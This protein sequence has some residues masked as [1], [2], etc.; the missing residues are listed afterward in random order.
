M[1]YYNGAVIAGLD[2]RDAP[3]LARDPDGTMTSIAAAL[4]DDKLA[5]RF[6]RV[7]SRRFQVTAELLS[8]SLEQLTWEVVSEVVQRA[9]DIPL[10]V[11]RSTHAVD[12]LAPGISKV[13]VLE[14]LRLTFG[15]GDRD[16]PVLCIGDRGRW[17]GNE[18]RLLAEPFS[19]S[20]DEVS[21]H[22]DSCWHVAPPGT[23]GTLATNYYLEHLN[24]RQG[25]ARISL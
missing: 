23:R 18:A 19:L 7:S 3:L 4:Q 21:P 13:S 24:I 25:T 2:Q 16:A 1:G 10:D 9:I 6:A 5:A 14:A 12:V 20:V 8:P 11:V 17:P 15:L 22:P